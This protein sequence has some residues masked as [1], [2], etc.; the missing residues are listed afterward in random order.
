MGKRNSRRNRA[1]HSNQPVAPE[2]LESRLLLTAKGGP[3]IVPGELLVQYNSG[4]TA[5][6]RNVARAGMGVQVAE[7]IQTKTMQKAGFGVMERVRLG[8]GM[9]MDAAIAKLKSNSR[10]KFVEPN[11][12]YKPAA[13]SDDTYYTNGS[14]WGMYGSDS[15]AASGPAG[16]TNQYGSNAE[17]AWN[18]NI[19]GSRSVVVGVI[20]EGIQTT[21]PDLAGNIWT[22]PGEVAGDGKIGRAH[23]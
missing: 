14:L 16:T 17:A 12:V 6:G 8:N 22:N 3:E 5:A 7:T 21:H 9:T 15:P 23:V 11:Y 10:V 4:V 19:T 20:D 18:A 1:N 13:V 2:I